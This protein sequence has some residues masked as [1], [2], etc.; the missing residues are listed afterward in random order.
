[1][2]TRDCGVERGGERREARL[3]L[4]KQTAVT[5]DKSGK[6]RQCQK[7]NSEGKRET[8]EKPDERKQVE[9]QTVKVTSQEN[10]TH[11]GSII[12]RHTTSEK[13]STAWFLLQN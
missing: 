9:E 10:H 8:K 5:G 13:V 6:R 1:M 12:Y 3:K 2:W 7:S 4:N 11:T